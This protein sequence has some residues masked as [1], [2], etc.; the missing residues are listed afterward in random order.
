[1][2]EEVTDAAV[3]DMTYAEA[4]VSVSGSTVNNSAGTV[5]AG[6]GALGTCPGF[7]SYD[8]AQKNDFTVSCENQGL[9]I[10]WGMAAPISKGKVTHDFS[11]TIP[12]TYYPT[13]TAS[14]C[15]GA[16]TSVNSD[17]RNLAGYTG[18]P[19]CYDITGTVVSGSVQSDPTLAT[20]QPFDNQSG[21]VAVSYGCNPSDTAY[22][23]TDGSGNFDFFAT[24]KQT[25]C[26]APS[27]TGANP[28]SPYT[29]CYLGSPSPPCGVSTTSYV[30]V[31]PPNYYPRTP[32]NG[33]TDNSAWKNWSTPQVCNTTTCGNYNFY[34]I[35]AG[36]SPIAKK[37]LD[38]SLFA[39]A[40]PDSGPGPSLTPGSTDNF[41]LT[42]TND[43]DSNNPS[44]TLTDDIPLNINPATVVV[45]SVTLVQFGGPLS[46]TV[47]TKSLPTGP[48]W[49]LPSES[50][51]YCY[52][53][54]SY[55]GQCGTATYGSSEGGG[56]TR[57]QISF[58]LNNMPAFSQLRV[59]WHGS[60]W[61][62]S[63]Q[64]GVYPGYANN[65][66]TRYCANESSVNYGSQS[67]ILANCQDF[68]NGY[69]GV[70]NFA[71]AS[72]GCQVNSSCPSV[73]T[74]SNVTYN[75]I[76]PPTVDLSACIA[77]NYTSGD[78]FD[79]NDSSLLGVT[80]SL[81][82]VAGCPNDITILN[83]SASPLVNYV[84][85]DPGSDD[86]TDYDT[87]TFNLEATFPTATAPAGP[88]YY[89]IDDQYGGANL[90][91][92]MTANNCTNA[93]SAI[94][95][96]VGCSG[97]AS[98]N[99][100]QHL[101]WPGIANIGGGNSSEVSFGVTWDNPDVHPIGGFACNTAQVTVYDYSVNPHA[102]TTS[103]SNQV[104]VK[105]V[106]VVRPAIQVTGN[107][108]DAGASTTTS[109]TPPTTPSTAFGTINT[110]PSTGQYVVSAS[111]AITNTL[112]GLP[113]RGFGSNTG[114]SGTGSSAGTL[115]QNNYGLTC[116]P[117][118]TQQV[119]S[120]IASSGGGTPINPGAINDGGNDGKI[121]VG[122]VPVGGTFQL[123]S[124]GTT[125]ITKRWTLYVNGNVYIDSNL[126]FS[127]TG[128][129][130]IVATG[131]IS[132]DPSVT[133][134]DAFLYGDTINTCE[135]G[136]GNTLGAPWTGLTCNNQLT[137]NGLV[138]ARHFRF[139]RTSTV[140]TSPSEIIKFSSQLYLYTPP[141]LSDIGL[142]EIN[143]NYELGSP[144][145]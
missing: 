40:L 17:D 144:R 84:Y 123:G 88:V 70:S 119:Q 79:D 139:N 105:H 11:V 121:M 65:G 49:L 55:T 81:V 22:L 54:A 120:D 25:F 44:A 32:Y 96:P 137:I 2:S 82:Q 108:V 50:S 66:D 83:P 114:N 76:P 72:A 31:R 20:G 85:S 19:L 33:A 73:A 24:Q 43:V 69:E 111:G 63:T 112:G 12:Q 106:N 28:V 10:K 86:T 5:N 53:D 67:S 16:Y 130:A 95:G 57:P 68:T 140:S 30:N 97:T 98:P 7:T 143:P 129:L 26:F 14:F 35:P 8:H 51:T 128:S 87:G 75:P 60:V 135:D 39:G 141:G 94:G 45:D 124:G 131:T 138:F 61:G 113:I 89:Y 27:T 36:S 15:F 64:I 21:I 101:T 122:N 34:W 103:P 4:G 127:P 1:V 3:L 126:A 117:N 6:G 18:E 142:N 132:I 23:S 42:S 38:P 80:P 58:T 46:W 29:W 100:S 99:G 92:A 136:S 13:G 47:F 91:S 41:Y 9:I 107:D 104:C 110:N 74:V 134:V 78:S 90:D 109:C 37:S 115:T 145:Y 116:L 93:T 71:T 102:S 56:S 59:Q 62:S 133:R 77:K 118:V 48:I 52:Y 125:N